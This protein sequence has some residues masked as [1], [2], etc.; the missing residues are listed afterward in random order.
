[1]RAE[2]NSL[3]GTHDFGAFRG[4][5]DQ[6]PETTRTIYSADFHEDPADPRVLWFEINGNKFLYHMVRIIVGTLVDVGRGRARP[7]AV[8][9][10]LASLD[11]TDL[12]ITAPP[13]GLFLT[14]VQLDEPVADTWPA[15]D[16]SKT[17]A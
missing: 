2:A 5:Q 14:H 13:Q 16:D 7:G 1:M 3:V 10:A 6:R 9:T 11:R 4:A 15:V 12:G 8:R 17:T